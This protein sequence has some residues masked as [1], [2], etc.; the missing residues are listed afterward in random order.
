M[1]LA[2]NHP[3]RCVVVLATL[4]LSLVA[5]C[6]RAPNI[7]STYGSMQGA[8]GLERLRA[9][10]G[11]DFGAPAGTPVLASADGEVENVDIDRRGCGLSI[12]LVHGAFDRYTLYC[13]LDRARVA[14]GDLV[15]RGQPIG[16]VGTSGSTGEVPHVHWELCTT[17]CPFGHGGSL[18]GTEDPM[19]RSDG[20]Y[21]AERRYREDRLRLTYP[22]PCAH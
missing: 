5:G 15:R 13:H 12:L 10:T 17:A 9:H 6:A 22:V 4:A 1:N 20:C 7:L 14:R 2:R 11:V 8:N 18:S 16:E 21:R 3:R 19:T